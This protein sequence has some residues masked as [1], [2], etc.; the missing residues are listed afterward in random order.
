MKIIY[1]IIVLL[2]IYVVCIVV[3]FKYV[4]SHSQLPTID[5]RD[6]ILGQGPSFKYIAAG[7][8][9]AVGQGASSAEQSYTYKIAQFLSNTNTVQYKNIGVIGAKTDDVINEQLT[10]IID[11]KPDIITLSIGANDVTHLHNKNKVL[12]NIRTILQDLTENTT[13]QIYITNIPIVDRTTLLPF[14]YRKI[15]EY[16]VKK[17]NPNIE[18]LESDRIHV[19][20]IHEFGWNRYAD[21][22]TTFAQDQFHPNDEGYANWANAFIFRIKE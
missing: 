12:K 7:D 4:L 8:S 17:I 6:Q 20:D 5:Q 15:L 18:A 16:K 3:R 10:K 11:F 9:T 13:A 14:P 19:I 21:I 22:R 1:T 2:S